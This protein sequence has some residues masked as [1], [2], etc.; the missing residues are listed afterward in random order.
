MLYFLWCK[1]TKG[2]SKNIFFFFRRKKENNLL[3]ICF[4]FFRRKETKEFAPKQ[5]FCG[6]VNFKYPLQAKLTEEVHFCS[7]SCLKNVTIYSLTKPTKHLP[8]G[9]K[10]KP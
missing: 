10:L 3:K 7:N 2:F 5:D 6:F 1:E 4:L 8:K 9:R